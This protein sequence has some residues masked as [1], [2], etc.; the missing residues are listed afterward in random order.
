MAECPVCGHG[1]SD[2]LV[3]TTIDGDPL[4]KERPRTTLTKNG[5]R[6]TYTPPT[7]QRAEAAIGWALR[8]ALP[9][10]V[11]ARAGAFAAR[12]GF[13]TKTRKPRDLDNMIK[14]VMDA[15]NKLVWNDDKQVL[16]LGAFVVRGSDRPRTTLELSLIQEPTDDGNDRDQDV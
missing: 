9:K 13:F 6:R 5:K 12:L 14:L 4:S 11:I 1:A 10:P 15:C 7:T 16:R 3:A 2:I 8:A